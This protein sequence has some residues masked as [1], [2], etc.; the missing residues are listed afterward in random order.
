M[1]SD[2]LYD[3]FRKDVV[4]TALPYLW[5]DTEVYAYMNDAYYMF[6]RLTGGIS[7]YLNDSVCLLTTAVDEKYSDLH[8]SILVVRSATLEPNGEAVHVINAQDVESLNDE[9][10]G[11]LRRLN[12]HTT[13]GKV[14]YMI[15]GLQQDV[16]QWVNIPNAA[17]NVRLLVERLPLEDI[18]GSGQEF[19][20]V[21]SHHHIHFLKWM[22]HLAYYKQD[23]ET[24]DRA[25]SDVCKADFVAYCD[26]AKRE[27][28]RYKHKVRV[29]RY[30]GI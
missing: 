18:T 26:M 1:T 25:K 21:K 3:L 5:S 10:F 20:G 6:V 11:L 9:D 2:E 7:D 23:A 27:K 12:M 15:V 22:K 29:V 24:F 16:V 14:R 13:K 28:D 17:Y 19:D 30:G 4:D 8:P